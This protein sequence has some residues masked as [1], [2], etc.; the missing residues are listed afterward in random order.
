MNLEGTNRWVKEADNLVVVV[1]VV[2]GFVDE[3]QNQGGE[4]WG[5]CYKW[6]S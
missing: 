3:I 5:L 4:T 1:F 6:V 2:V